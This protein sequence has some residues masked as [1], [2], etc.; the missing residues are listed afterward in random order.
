MFA[1]A[2]RP[3]SAETGEST[4]PLA[5]P[6]NKPADTNEQGLIDSDPSPIKSEHEQ[7]RA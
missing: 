3:F 6:A 5:K 7:G 1:S 4:A 2:E